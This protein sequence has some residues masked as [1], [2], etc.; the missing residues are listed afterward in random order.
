MTVIK[1]YPI[2][3]TIIYIYYKVT[4]KCYPSCMVR[5][6]VHS[7][8]YK[9]LT[10]KKMNAALNKLFSNSIHTSQCLSYPTFYNMIIVSQT[11][12]MGW[13]SLHACNNSPPLYPHISLSVEQRLFIQD[14]YTHSSLPPTAHTLATSHTTH[15][16]HHFKIWGHEIILKIIKNKN[17]TNRNKSINKIY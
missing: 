1:F 10:L 14:K 17:T 7:L 12:S 3:T 15:P 5:F 13:H 2:I 6:T 8:F 11:C 16:F 4:D 9:T